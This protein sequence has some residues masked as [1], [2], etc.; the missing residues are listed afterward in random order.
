M[1]KYWQDL[2]PMTHDSWPFWLTCST[3][4]L[5]QFE[6]SQTFSPAKCPKITFNNILF[7]NS[8]FSLSFKVQS[9]C[10]TKVSYFDIQIFSKEKIA[11]FQIPVDYFAI[12]QI[13]ASFHH[14]FDKILSLGLGDGS[15]PF[16]HFHQW[17]EETKRKEKEKQWLDRNKAEHW[18]IV[19]IISTHKMIPILFKLYKL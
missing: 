13:L 8:P 10:K 17:L 7:T 12:V 15:S 19:E 3:G 14:L 11:K 5:D 16:V 2:T 9:G 18:E 1:F 4:I 6:I